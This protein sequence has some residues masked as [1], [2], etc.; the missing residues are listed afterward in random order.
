M[1]Q[2]GA[3]GGFEGRRIVHD[4]MI[5]M[6]QGSRRQGVPSIMAVAGRSFLRRLS[7]GITGR[8]FLPVTGWGVKA[9]AKEPRQNRRFHACETA[10]FCRMALFYADLPNRGCLTDVRHDRGKFKCPVN[11]LVSERKPR[12]FGKKFEIRISKSETMTKTEMFQ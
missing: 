11:E 12:F 3:A 8:I 4:I 5:A 1:G 9:R 2:G 6:K 7:D 10:F